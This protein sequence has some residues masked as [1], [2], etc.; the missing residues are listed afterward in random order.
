MDYGFFLNFS[1]FRGFMDQS[2]FRNDGSIAKNENRSVHCLVRLQNYY[3]T[4][5]Q[6]HGGY[7]HHNIVLL[8]P[9]SSVFAFTDSV[10]FYFNFFFIISYKRSSKEILMWKF[11]I[12]NKA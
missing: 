3:L 5:T 1:Y 7:I 10:R 8:D 2:D 6:D 9:K 12:A 11:F 4:V